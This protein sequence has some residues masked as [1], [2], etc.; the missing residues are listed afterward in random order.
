[1][2]AIGIV[3]DACG[4]HAADATGR[5]SYVLASS[6]TSP[7]TVLPGAR[8]MSCECCGAVWDLLHPGDEFLVGVSRVVRPRGLL[9]DVFNEPIPVPK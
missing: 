8:P 3:C 2:R 4:H 9:V 1:M 5:T 6:D 7:S